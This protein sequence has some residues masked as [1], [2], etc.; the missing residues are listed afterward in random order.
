[1]AVLH[2]PADSRTLVLQSS[3]ANNPAKLGLN[4]IYEVEVDAD[5]FVRRLPWAS[6]AL[7][8]FYFFVARDHDMLTHFQ[9]AAQQK[10]S[11]SAECDDP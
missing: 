1:M 3:R 9:G 8:K 4:L 2:C 5:V 7:L 10:S 6:A 11:I